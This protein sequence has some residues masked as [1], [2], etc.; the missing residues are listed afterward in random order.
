[1]E[2]ISY[3]WVLV[4]Y[5]LCGVLAMAKQWK[6]VYVIFP[7]L[8]CAVY[9]LQRPKTFEGFVLLVM[10]ASVPSLIAAAA[11]YAIVVFVRFVRNMRE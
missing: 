10:H 6:I 8:C 2:S 9:F 7:A 1:M 11:V 5:F 4:G 3:F